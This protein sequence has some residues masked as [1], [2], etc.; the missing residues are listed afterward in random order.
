MNNLNDQHL[1]N[2][3]YVKSTHQNEIMRW[4]VLNSRLKIKQLQIITNIYED[5]VA[6]IVCNIIEY[7]LTSE[8]Q[9]RWKT[10]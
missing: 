10:A 6:F 1:K 5:V 8:L 3:A 9:T 2:M 7:L 4:I